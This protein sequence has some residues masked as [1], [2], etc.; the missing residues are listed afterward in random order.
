MMESLPEPAQNQVVEHLRG[1]LLEM[2]DELRR[3]ASFNRTQ[4]RL[5]AMARRA[6][7][8]IAEGKARPFDTPMNYN[9][10]DASVVL[11]SVPVIG[12]GDPQ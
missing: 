5:T 4:P 2:Q 8:Q 7:E 6:K 11:A 10:S 3:H 12:T 9:V 1:Y